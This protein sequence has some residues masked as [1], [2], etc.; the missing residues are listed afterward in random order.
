MLNVPGTIVRSGTPACV[1][2][3]LLTPEP[4][5]GFQAADHLGCFFRPNDAGSTRQECLVHTEHEI[6][7]F[8]YF[9]RSAP[10]LGWPVESP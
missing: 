6:L 8:L 5:T 2:F 1:L 9:E 10:A 3:S 4:A 7:I